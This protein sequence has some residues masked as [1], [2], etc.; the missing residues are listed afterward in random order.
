MHHALRVPSSAMSLAHLLDPQPDTHN[1]SGCGMLETESSLMNMLPR[2]VIQGVQ[3]LMYPEGPYI[4]V[5]ERIRILHALHKDFCLSQVDTVPVRNWWLYRA[6]LQIDSSQYIGDAEIHFGAPKETPDGTNPVTCGQTSAIGNALTY[7]GYGDL[8]LL[9]EW[10]HLHAEEGRACYP[11]TPPYGAIKGVRV[12]WLDE[13][14]Y[15]PVAERLYHLH[16]LGH[17]L[18]MERCDIIRVHGL[19]VYRVILTVDGRRYIGDAEVRFAAKDPAPER[20]FPLSTAQTSAVGNALALA[21]F[22][23]VRAILERRGIDTEG[24]C[25][26]PSLASADVVMQAQQ[27]RQKRGAQEHQSDQEAAPSA[28]VGTLAL[29]TREQQAEIRRLCANLGEPEPEAMKEWTCEEAST[30]IEILHIQ[31]DELLSTVDAVRL[32]PGNGN[33]TTHEAE[34]S[35]REVGTLKRAWMQAFGVQEAPDIR[36]RWEAFKEQHCHTPVDDNSMLHSQFHLLKDAIDQ[37]SAEQAASSHAKGHTTKQAK[38]RTHQK[39]GQS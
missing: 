24:V 10:Q 6:T 7:A 33:P 29:I 20:R 28:Q 9:L 25:W 36:Q 31:M 38:K 14:P 21:G 4:E 13:T 3:A 27:E 15:V 8:A 19:W 12:V 1:A 34:A 22:G 23:D 16:Q 32:A 5:V 18:S 2:Q 35:H 39:D 26:A 30:Y 37:H 11:D 17:T